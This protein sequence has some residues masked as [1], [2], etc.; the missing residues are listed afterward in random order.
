[1]HLLTWEVA[2]NLERPYGRYWQKLRLRVF[3]RGSYQCQ[4]C[5]QICV[6]RHR[7]DRVIV[8][9]KSGLYPLR[10]LCSGV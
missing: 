7:F 8:N 6:G 4:I 10:P 2:L 3:L 1:M 9:E 5:N